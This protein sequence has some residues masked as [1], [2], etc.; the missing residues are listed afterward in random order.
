MPSEGPALSATEIQAVERWIAGGGFIPDKQ[1]NQSLASIAASRQVSAPP[2]YPKPLPVHAI[3]FHP[4]GKEIFVGGY[5]EILRW[6][7]RDQTLQQRIPVFGEHVFSISVHPNG[8]R[9]AVASGTPGIIGKVELVML[10]DPNNRLVLCTQSDVPPDVAFAPDGNHLAVA[11]HYGNL[12]L[13][14][15][16]S[17]ADPK[18]IADL[19]S[20]A[21]SI[22]SVAWSEDG[23]RFITSSR[24][25]TAKL[26][27]GNRA[28]LIVSYDR[29]ERA[30]GGGAFLGTRT[31]TLDE[32][33]KLR[34]WQGD[35][36]DRVLAEFSGLPRNL[37]KVVAWDQ[38]V[39]V[40][41]R[42]RIR[43]FSHHTATVDDGTDK[44]GKPK[45]RQVHKIKEQTVFTT[46]SQASPAV[47]LVSLTIAR[48]NLAA[49]SMQGDVWVWN[50]QTAEPLL[51]WTA[52]P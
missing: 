31:V 29:H 51:H 16:R 24:D 11:G 44:D 15:I 14:D 48:D 33:G 17:D 50:I 13:F 25:R 42:D 35:D 46:S 41:D 3:C 10:T 32:T 21:D 34:L 47:E 23:K 6:S 18:P 38:K 36:E 8:N 22:L 9:M 52:K 37:Q 28:E 1:R 4:N 27:D 26:F 39:W 5:A 20:H 49:G 19:T 40:I 2:H 7:V 30:V 12:Q 43:S 45:K